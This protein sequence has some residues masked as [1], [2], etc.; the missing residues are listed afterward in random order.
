MKVSKRDVL[1]LLALV[2]I[3]A[4]V[5]S[6]FLVYQPTME[7]AQALEQENEQLQKRIDDL[8]SKMGNRDTYESETERM[9]EE[10]EVIYQ[11]FPV[12]VREENAILLAINQELLAPM[13]INTL[14]IE[15]LADV[16]ITGAEEEEDVQ[17]TYEIDEIEKLEAQEGIVD[18][19]TAGSSITSADGT[20]NPFGLKTRK[21]TM[22]YEVSYEGLKRSVKNLC[23]QTDRMTINEVTVAYDENSGLLKGSTMMD[24]YCI[25]GQ[26]G[27]E[28]VEPDFGH[29]LLG[30]DNIFGTIRVPGEANL[31]DLEDETDED[32][33]AE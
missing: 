8:S 6:Y 11:L 18:E 24:M 15:P 17:Y 20:Y 14:T 19:E 33:Q 9:R 27:K 16:P 32:A 23:M 21:V 7:E 13:E 29:I 22:N 28:Y 12:D 30:T 4:V 2:G 3:L 10:I 5:G 1:I 31:P 26:E 25:P